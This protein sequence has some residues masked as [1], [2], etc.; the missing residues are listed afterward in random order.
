[1][2][3]VRAGS[4]RLR[5]TGLVTDELVADDDVAD[6]VAHNN[7]TGGGDPAVEEL[8]SLAP[9]QRIVFGGNRTVQVTDELAAAFEPGDRLIVV[10]DTGD[11]LHIPEHEWTTAAAAVERAHR[12]FLAPRLG[13]RRCRLRVL[14]A[15]RVAARRR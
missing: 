13:R 12:A 15:V 11:L 9:G 3:Q 5:Q 10:D 8:T 14:R 7:G 4:Y 6:D 1:M 2:A